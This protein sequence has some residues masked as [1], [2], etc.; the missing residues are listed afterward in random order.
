MCYFGELACLCFIVSC[1]EI[2]VKDTLSFFIFIFLF[3]CSRLLSC[4]EIMTE[5]KRRLMLTCLCC[6][7]FLAFLTSFFPFYWCSPGKAGAQGSRGDWS[8]GFK[9]SG[10]GRSERGY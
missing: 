10:G 2:T 8:G 6:F 9:R 5:D 7:F 4:K 1:K 3:S